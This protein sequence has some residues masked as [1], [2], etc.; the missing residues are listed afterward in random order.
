LIEYTTPVGKVRLLIS[1]VNEADLLLSD[2]QL[3]ALLSLSSDNIYRAAS[4]A[5]R[6]IAT[7][8]VLVSKVI[9]MQNGTST[10][11]AKV[12][13]ELR[14]LADELDSEA[15]RLDLLVDD[16]FFEI[17]PNEDPHAEAA[18]WYIS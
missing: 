6:I 1:D 18:E 15:R 11:G 12:S 9:R 4:K 8:E 17:V 10:D 14:A 7:S 13:A 16:S 5:L 3:T 2:E